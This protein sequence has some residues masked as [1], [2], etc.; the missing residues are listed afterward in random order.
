SSNVKDA[1][2]PGVTIED[3]LTQWADH[4]S[5]HGCH[6]LCEL[7][8]DGILRLDAA[9]ARQGSVT[10][11]HDFSKVFERLLVAGIAQELGDGGKARGRAW[12]EKRGAGGSMAIRTVFPLK[13]DAIDS[14]EIA[15]DSDAALG[16]RAV[17]GNGSDVTG[18]IAHGGEEVEINGCF[19][20]RRAL[21]R[22]QHVENQGRV[23][24]GM[25]PRSGIPSGHEKSS[26]NAGYF[27][28]NLRS[29]IASVILTNDG[30]QSF[31]GVT[32]RWFVNYR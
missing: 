25:R 24:R 2:G 15:E 18:A 32:A 11:T 31:L 17:A 20:G 1:D 22:L 8:P 12:I 16:C 26:S 19:K 4:H 14:Q 9:V 5:H 23:N 3:Y 30:L 28:G 6:A 27:G 10:R 29:S 7:H 21:M 13:K